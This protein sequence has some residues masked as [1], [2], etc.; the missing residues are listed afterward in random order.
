MADVKAFASDK[1]PKALY[2][3]CLKNT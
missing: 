2:A 1:H 3:E